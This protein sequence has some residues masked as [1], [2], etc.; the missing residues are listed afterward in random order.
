MQIESTIAY[1]KNLEIT[2]AQIVAAAREFLGLPY[3]TQGRDE[4]GTDCG[5]LLLLVGRKLDITDLE[6]LGYA[7]NPDGKTFK[8]LLDMVLR[9]ITPK[10]NV[11]IGDVLAMDYGS[12]IQHT[13][14]VTDVI[15][16]ANKSCGKLIKLIH[17]KRPRSGFGGRDR[18]VIE[19]YLHGYDERAW[20]A[21]YRIHGVK[22]EN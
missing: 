18:G 13:G 10:E 19:Q 6:V 1:N 12:G 15:Q 20:C 14:Y 21:T 3:R 9:E 11:Q 7:N 2:G 16:D 8:E 17:A 5:G 4:F 22:D